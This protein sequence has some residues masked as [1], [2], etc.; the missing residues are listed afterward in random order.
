MQIATARLML[1]EFRESDFGAVWAYESRP[2]THYY[3]RGLPT[4]EAARAYLEQA[5]VYARETPRTHYR[6]ALTVCPDDVPRGRIALTL[7]FAES[8]EWEIGWAVDPACWGQGYATEAAQGMLD[9]AFKDLNA[10]R[11]VAFCKS[12]NKASWRVMEKLGMQREG[13]LREESLWQG[14]F[15]DAFVYSILD[16]EWT[17]R[18]SDR[19]QGRESTR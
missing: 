9:Y 13:R 19:N 18:G 1:R 17:A 7:N 16:R 4:E 14:A 12:M 6:L 15:V 11:V 5:A 10:H 3:D 2:E 8:R